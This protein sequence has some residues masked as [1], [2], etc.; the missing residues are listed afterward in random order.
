MKSSLVLISLL[1]ISL[2]SAQSDKNVEDHQ[3]KIN[4]L[5]PGIIYEVGIQKNSTLNFQLG[6]AFG[7]GLNSESD[8][9]F[10]FFPIV[11]TQYRHY[12]NFNRRLKKGKNTEKNTANYVGLTTVYTSGN[13]VLGDYDLDNSNNFFVRPIYGLQRTYK[14]GFNFGIEFGAGYF[15]NNRAQGITIGADFTIGWVM[16]KNRNHGLG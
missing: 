13:A 1:L 11:E 15:N 12:Y 10:G 16:G 3:F 6:A 7:L 9:D 4:F 8:V 14:R 2:A 5:S